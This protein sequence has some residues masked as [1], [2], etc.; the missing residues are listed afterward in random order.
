MEL[1]E[2]LVRLLE[3]ERTP[4][5][6]SFLQ[7]DEAQATGQ[8]GSS[9]FRQ[10]DEEESFSGFQVGQPG[11]RSYSRVSTF[12]FDSPGRQQDFASPMWY[13]AASDTAIVRGLLP[14]TNCCIAVPQDRWIAVEQFGKFEAVLEPGLHFAG[15]DLL[16]CCVQFRSTNKRVQQQLCKITSI[17]KDKLFI[18]VHVA[19]QRSVLP[20]NVGQAIYSVTDM[21]KQVEAAVADIVRSLVPQYTLDE[22]FALSEELSQSIRTP[23]VEQIGQ[24]GIHIHQ[25]NVTD[26]KPASDVVEAMNNVKVQSNFLQKSILE[27]DATKICTVRRAEAEADALELQGQGTAR[28][29][30]AIVSGISG[31][32][33]QLTT[34]QTVEL[35]LMSEYCEMLKALV[36]KSEGH[37]HAIFL[38][39]VADNGQKDGRPTTSRSQPRSLVNSF[40]SRNLLD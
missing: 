26:I 6:E 7:N 5:L 39:K 37:T 12:D 22:F 13:D 32:I 17:T 3:D 23:L 14:C 29:R 16:G 19:V 9:A 33:E 31:A 27:A 4:L 30:G 40:S 21:G 24:Y 20:E 35:M 36:S 10:P 1:L 28:L 15:L 8:Q 18:A 25:V 2:A 38:K 11:R 34:S